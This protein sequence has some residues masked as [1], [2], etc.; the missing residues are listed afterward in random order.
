VQLDLT[1]SNSNLVVQGKLVLH[2]TTNLSTPAT[3]SRRL[4]SWLAQNDPP[5]DESSPLVNNLSGTGTSALSLTSSSHATAVGTTT[6]ETITPIAA[7]SASIIPRTQDITHQQ[8]SPSNARKPD[9]SGTLAAV[10][11]QSPK[12][13]PSPGNDAAGME[14]ASNNSAQQTRNA[15]ENQSTALPPGWEERFTPEARPYYVDHNTRATTWVD[16]RRQISTRGPNGQSGAL[17]S[18]WEMRQSTSS[19]LYFVDHNTR[20]TTWD[21][22][23]VP[24]SLD[25]SVPQYKEDFGSKLAY[26]RSQPVMDVRPGIGKIKVRRSHVFEDSYLEI[27]RQKPDDLKKRL[28]IRF[29]GEDGSEY[30]SH[31][32]LV[33]NIAMLIWYLVASHPYNIESF[34][35][36]SHASCST[37]LVVFSNIRH[38]TSRRCRSIPPPARIPSI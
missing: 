2:F 24:S 31:T 13:S 36:C 22:P 21:D 6:P 29:E 17:P 18:G 34:V 4:D 7:T 3:S 16:P 25:K 15:T 27:M 28:M 14:A 19:R 11:P 23:R 32:R 10:R 20:T 38:M 1:T 5:S 30:G 35:S 12:R 33:S 26:L 8:P 37:P 9:S